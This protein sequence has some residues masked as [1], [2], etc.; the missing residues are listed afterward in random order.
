MSQRTLN[1]YNSW[2]ESRSVVLLII[3]LTF[4]PNNTA[5]S[6][7]SVAKWGIQEEVCKGYS[8]AD[9]G[10]LIVFCVYDAMALA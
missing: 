10:S 5:A 1:A 8:L 3:N 4:F 7:S 2:L 9:G 6:Y